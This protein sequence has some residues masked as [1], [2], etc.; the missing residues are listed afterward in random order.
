MSWVSGA[1]FHPFPTR[2]MADQIRK[3]LIEVDRMRRIAGHQYR[4]SK[5]SE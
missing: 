2:A 4:V 3:E 1:T 5:Y